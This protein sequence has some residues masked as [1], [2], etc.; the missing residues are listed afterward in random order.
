LTRLVQIWLRTRNYLFRGKRIPFS[1]M[2]L[3][4]ILRIL[5]SVQRV[6]GF[7][8]YLI[9]RTT[10][11]SRVICSFNRWF[12]QLAYFIYHLIAIIAI[13]LRNLNTLGSNGYVT[14]SYNFVTMK[15][16]T[17]V[18]FSTGCLL[19]FNNLLN[20]KR[21][22]RF[23]CYVSK[24]HRECLVIDSFHFGL[25]L[26]L[27]FLVVSTEVSLLTPL[28]WTSDSSF[29]TVITWWADFE[30]QLVVALS[31]FSLSIFTLVITRNLD[32]I[33]RSG[34][35]K[36]PQSS[37][38]DLEAQNIQSEKKIDTNVINELKDMR[39]VL[40]GVQTTYQISVLSITVYVQVLYILYI[41]RV[42]GY[43][44]ERESLD[45]MLLTI[46]SL[47]SICLQT[48]EIFIL[49][50]SQHQYQQTVSITYH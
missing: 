6:F 46:Y 4:T 8:P 2:K 42:F 22:K 41:L 40:E 37:S 10:N 24:Y 19:K 43:G 47:F 31:I 29:E 30:F 38:R 17:V 34:R 26:A 18:W 11:S 16:G 50:N 35:K 36:I 23:F 20:Y 32:F 27:I 3:Y 9:H 45:K 28:T 15:F 33:T 7:S 44:H 48:L 49:Y 14:D 25:S 12:Y 13:L 1:E 39:K 5:M 21:I